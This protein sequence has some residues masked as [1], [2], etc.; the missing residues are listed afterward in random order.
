M[1]DNK[2][3]VNADRKENNSHNHDHV[4][5]VQNHET[6]EH[7]NFK[8]HEIQASSQA[9]NQ[10]N[11]QA[12]NQTN[13]QKT[14]ETTWEEEFEKH[15]HQ[16]NQD[17]IKAVDPE[18]HQ[19][20]FNEALHFFQEQQN[21]IITAG[22]K[23]RKLLRVV[24][25]ELETL[26]EEPSLVES[27]EYF[28]TTL[29]ALA[30]VA[31]LRDPETA[32]HLERTREYSFLL[33]EKMNLDEDFCEKIYRVGPL[34]DIGKVG[35]KDSILLKPGKLSDE[36]FAEM[37]KHTLIGAD[38][39]RNVIGKHKV[40]ETYIKMAEDITRS[41]HEKYDG[42]GYPQKVVGED[43]PLAAR[44][45]ALADAYDAIRSRRPYKDP[46]PHEVAMERIR[47]D[48]G[49]HFDPLVVKAFL[50]I[51]EKFAEINDKYQ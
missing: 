21:K 34:H 50:E 13:N 51:N 46:L 27:E 26:D 4:R 49:T 1:T 47:K 9:N 16:L 28:E 22:N 15:L 31:E 48:A 33:A 3:T 5:N 39:V 7:I 37:Q 41:H 42:S 35:I 8:E 38:T 10:D 40:E 20:V 23:I 30:K 11:N 45:F 44:I 6:H 36:E 17:L 2:K 32:F 29:F 24:G 14:R 18:T 25:K 43:I 19:Q 12:N